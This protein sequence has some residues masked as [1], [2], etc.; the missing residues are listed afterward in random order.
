MRRLHQTEVRVGSIPELAAEWLGQ[1]KASF[2]ALARIVLPR[3]FFND[4]ERLELSLL[5]P[6]RQS[7]SAHKNLSTLWE[8]RCEADRPVSHLIASLTSDQP[9]TAV[10]HAT[11]GCALR[12]AITLPASIHNRQLR[13]S[14]E[15]VLEAE[16]PFRRDQ[17]HWGFRAGSG[18]RGGKR[19]I[20][21]VVVPK[22]LVDPHTETLRE[23]GIHLRELCYREDVASEA[24]I[25]LVRYPAQR[26]RHSHRLLL[27]L[28]IVAFLQVTA[29]AAIP[30]V[31]HTIQTT[32]F[33]EETTRLSTIAADLGGLQSS[34]EKAMQPVRQ[35]QLELQSSPSSAAVL[36]IL[37][38]ELGKDTVLDRLSV[39][40]VLVQA[41]GS[42]PRVDELTVRLEK[43]QNLK[44]KSIT[45][46]GVNAVGQELFSVA[47]ELTSGEGR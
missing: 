22:S 1:I 28:G 20:D 14:L 43:S 32:R 10:I 34:L 35:A 36:R 3:S 23:N 7:I 33:N 42:T 30:L 47:L 16:T 5:S 31:A 44:P 18:R 41:T 17:V 11:P 21:L 25:S 39:R 13:Q 8:E 26:E 4:D 37:E 45:R 38:A 24:P 6:S 46:N 19:S 29:A 27:A 40:G 15:Y 2:S 9:K 12:K